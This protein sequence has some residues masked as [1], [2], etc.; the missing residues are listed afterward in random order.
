[1][2]SRELTKKAQ[3]HKKQLE[4]LF[5]VKYIWYFIWYDLWDK[6]GK[7]ASSCGKRK[8][9]TKQDFPLT[10][11]KPAHLAGGLVFGAA[12]AKTCAFRAHLPTAAADFSPHRARNDVKPSRLH[13]PLL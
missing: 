10:A 2:P 9:K 8:Q 13:A 3:K 1:M 5:K 12:A 4:N 7:G 6:A 11:L